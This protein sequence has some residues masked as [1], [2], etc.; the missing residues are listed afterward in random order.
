[1]KRAWIRLCGGVAGFV[2]SYCA[3]MGILTLA[4]LAVAFIIWQLP[5]LE[6]FLIWIRI[7][8]IFALVVSLTYAFSDKCIEVG[9]KP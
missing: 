2:F 6:L 7:S 4:T 1:M 5:P 9:E 3:V 8:A